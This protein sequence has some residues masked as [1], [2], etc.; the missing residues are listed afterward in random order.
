MPRQDH[1]GHRRETVPCGVLHWS[2]EQGYKHGGSPAFLLRFHGWECLL[3][4]ESLEL[5]AALLR[6]CANWDFFSRGLS[7]SQNCV[8]SHKN[9][10]R[11]ISSKDW[12]PFPIIFQ[13]LFQAWSARTSQWNRV[14][15]FYFNEGQRAHFS[16]KS[17]SEGRYSLWNLHIWMGDCLWGCFAPAKI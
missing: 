9:R 15:L 16:L 8:V 14:R 2:I 11:H 17:S 3:Q 10:K 7:H 6:T 4:T 1:S 12:L 13:V 5:L